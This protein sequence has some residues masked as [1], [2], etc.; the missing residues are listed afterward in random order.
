VFINNHTAVWGSWFDVSTGIWGYACCHSS[1]HASYCAGEA[2]I[3][4]AR[5]SS[6]SHLLAAAPA[7]S[8][9]PPPVPVKA[10]VDEEEDGDAA[11]RRRRA[12][13]AFSKKRLGEGDV[14]IDR[15]RL[16][17]ALAEERKRKAVRGEADDPGPGKRRKGMP[18]NNSFE[19]TEEAMGGSFNILLG[20]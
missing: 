7:A 1:I 20:R 4:A 6:A 11:D 19:V 12:E 16:E 9:P 8:M 5:Q 14:Q 3:E 15:S 10:Q 18:D 13:T 17:R 2:G